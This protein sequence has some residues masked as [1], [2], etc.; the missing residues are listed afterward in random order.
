MEEVSAYNEEAQQRLREAV[1][2]KEGNEDKKTVL[3]ETVVPADTRGG[4]AAMATDEV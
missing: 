4:N 2:R 1:E 3:T